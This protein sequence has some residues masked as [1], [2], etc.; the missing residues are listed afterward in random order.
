MV[1]FGEITEKNWIK[2]QAKQAVAGLDRATTIRMSSK[3]FKLDSIIK[4]LSEE[5]KNT[6][7]TLYDH[8]TVLV[9]HPYPQKENKDEWQ[10]NNL[11]RQMKMIKRFIDN[12]H[13]NCTVDVKE[14]DYYKEEIE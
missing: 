2:K 11:Q 8:V 14:L 12:E 10:S 1:K 13:T 5:D 4:K 7:E 3:L 9:H 6:G